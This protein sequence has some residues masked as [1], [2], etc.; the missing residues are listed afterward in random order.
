MQL[1]VQKRHIQIALKYILLKYIIS[2]ISSSFEKHAK[3]NIFF[4]KGMD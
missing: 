1:S 4:H 3:D 2:L